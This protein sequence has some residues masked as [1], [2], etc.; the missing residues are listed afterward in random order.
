MSFLKA[1]A[2]Y[3]CRRPLISDLNLLLV[4]R[5]PSSR[6]QVSTL[7]TMRR[8]PLRIPKIAK[9]SPFVCNLKNVDSCAML[10]SCCTSWNIQG[11]WCLGLGNHNESPGAKLKEI[12]VGTLSLTFDS[13]QRP[14]GSPGH[15]SPCSTD[16][17][18][19]NKRTMKKLC[20]Q[21]EQCDYTV[22]QRRPPTYLRWPPT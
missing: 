12:K 11:E 6:A 5:S 18:V 14:V 10:Q 19:Q 17:T 7:P 2:L 9:R 22:W 20:A 8:G 13:F 1:S 16:A 4:P 15:S 3:I 21:H